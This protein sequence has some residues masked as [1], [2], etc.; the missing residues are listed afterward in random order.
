VPA[1]PPAVAAT[2]REA[3]LEA[4]IQQLEAMVNQLQYQVGQPGTGTVPNQPGT[5]GG[6][7]AEGSGLPPSE[8]GTTPTAGAVETGALPRQSVSSSGGIGVPGQ[9]FPPVP[10]P[11]DR[12]NVPATLEDKRGR[13]RFGPG[14]ELVTDDQ[15]FIL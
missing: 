2:S 1:I 9:S 5:T 14:F 12:F 15:E 10:P 4:R 13:F 7:G 8:P 3:Q 6:L 11:S